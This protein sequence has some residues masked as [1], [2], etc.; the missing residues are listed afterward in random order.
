MY[1]LLQRSVSDVNW[2]DGTFPIVRL[3]LIDHFTFAVRLQQQFNRFIFKLEQQEYE[4]EKIAWSFISFPDNQDVLDLIEKKHSGIFSILDEQCKLA[5]CTDSSFSRALYEKCEEHN[6]FQSSRTQ[7]AR[8]LFAVQHYA[9]N[10]EYDTSSFLNKNKDE[11]PKEATDFLLSSRASTVRKLGEILSDSSNHDN[12]GNN[13]RKFNN[14]KSTLS[15]ASVGNQFTSQLRE[16]R[17]RIELTSP[18]YIRCMKPNDELTPDNF[19]PAVIAN[20]LNCAGVLEAVRVSRVGYPQRY[21]KDLF[22]RRYLILCITAME[23]GK[24]RRGDLCDE[25]VEIL[26]PKIWCEQRG[27]ADEQNDQQSSITYVYL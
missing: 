12:S 6:C 24:R 7:K 25:L 11:L 10:V 13:G 2:I 27:N 1:K 14:A 23:R 15:R 5:K 19:V 9:G 4:K 17:C 26:V 20:Q 16:L 8:G 22:V 3:E 21:T 18:H